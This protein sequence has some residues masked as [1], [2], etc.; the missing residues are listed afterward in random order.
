MSEHHRRIDRRTFIK[1]VG[2]AALLATAV[3]ATGG[4]LLRDN[5]QFADPPAEPIFHG[6]ERVEDN[7]LQ[8]FAHF[9]K[10]RINTSHDAPFWDSFL[11]YASNTK[12]A[13][14]TSHT[15]IIPA[16]GGSRDNSFTVLAQW[17]DEMRPDQEYAFNTTFI[18]YRGQEHGK[19]RLRDYRHLSFG[20]SYDGSVSLDRT[21]GYPNLI[22]EEGELRNK[23]D[24]ASVLNGN[25]HGASYSK[26]LDGRGRIESVSYRATDGKTEFFSVLSKNL[27]MTVSSFTD[28]NAKPP[29]TTLLA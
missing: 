11:H 22:Q 17:P 20:L 27:Q 18:Y 2:K 16:V 15:Q 9:A 14:L 10:T 6:V 8:E 21:H 25:T 1:S 29:H 19:G 13:P 23:L 5:L 26:Q 28:L 7:L 3:G 12:S 24:Y 4:V